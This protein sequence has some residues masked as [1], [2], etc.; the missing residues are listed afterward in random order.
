MN[1][2]RDSVG[3][4]LGCDMPLLCQPN[5]YFARHMLSVCLST[6]WPHLTAGLIPSPT[7]RWTFPTLTLLQPSVRRTV[8]A[9]IHVSL[10]LLLFWSFSCFEWKLKSYHLEK[11]QPVVLV[12]WDFFQ[13]QWP[14][15]PRQISISLKK[16]KLIVWI[17]TPSNHLPLTF[18][19]PSTQFPHTFHT[20]STR[21]QH[22]YKT[23]TNKNQQNNN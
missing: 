18:H 14:F 12:S 6:L 11:P 10:L 15:L 5:Q 3:L 2:S 7:W 1:I 20:D 19:T 17:H 16:F 9:C 13:V 23:T 22:N 21:H 4:P 8:R